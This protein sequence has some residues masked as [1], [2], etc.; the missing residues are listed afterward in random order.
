MSKGLLGIDASHLVFRSV[1]VDHGDRTPP[2]GPLEVLG[3]AERIRAMLQIAAVAVAR[4]STRPKRNAK[5]REYLEFSDGTVGITLHTG[6]DEICLFLEFGQF[7][8]LR[9][10]APVHWENAGI[11]HIRSAIVLFAAAVDGLADQTR[12]VQAHRLL[13]RRA[14]GMIAAGASSATFGAPMPWSWSGKDHGGLIPAVDVAIKSRS[15]LVELMI[16]DMSVTLRRD[17]L[18]PIELMRLLAD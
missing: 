6:D 9:A 12:G 13:V 11:R 1:P 16:S 3:A 18:D 2:P 8:G 14:A 4:P 10:T 7:E 5:G 17:E 15:K